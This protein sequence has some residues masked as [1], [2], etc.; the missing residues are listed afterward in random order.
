MS[1]KSVDILL[2]EDDGRLADLTAE[3]FEQN[4]LSVSIE[5]RGDRALAQFAKLRPRVVLLDL[6]LPGV[7]GLTICRELREIFDGPILIFTA[8]DSDSGSTVC[9][10]PLP[11]LS[12]PMMMARE[13]SC[14]APATISEA[15]AVPSLTR[16]TM[17]KS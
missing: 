13:W 6:M 10:E 5:S 2:V 4:G 1:S 9:T 14:K 11:K 8:R 12:V 7:D 17:G 16:S 3:Y 15:L